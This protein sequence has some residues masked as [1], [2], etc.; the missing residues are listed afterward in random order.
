MKKLRNAMFVFLLLTAVICVTL[1]LLF[2]HYS[3]PVGGSSENIKIEI[4][5]NGSQIAEKLKE[6]DLIRSTTFFKIYLKL[7]KVNDLKAGKYDLNK[8]MSLKE[9]VDKLKE[10]NHFSE[11]EISITFKEGITMRDI[12]KVIDANTNNTYDDVMNV[13]KDTEYLKSLVNDYWFITDKILDS[14]IYYPLEGYLFPDTYRFT[15]KEVTVKEIFKKLLDQMDKVLT[16]HKD[17]IENNKYN[18]HEILTL[19]SLCEKEIGSKEE[20]RKNVASVFI[21][22]LNR[23]MSLGS[24]VTTRYSLKI[25]DPK[26]VLK[27]SEYAS[28]NAYNTRS[29]TMAGKLPAGPISTVSEGSILAVLNAPK[30]DYIYFIANIQTGET[31]F[32]TNARE[33]EAKKAELSKING[34]L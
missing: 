26:Q 11:E 3:S 2:R 27:K 28:V 18:V 20:Y 30:T 8:E 21:N 13:F 24:D 25:D 32:Y 17:L 4:S 9:I 6:A 15:S 16:P 10:G 7:F 19:A 23:G 5:G 1:G 29:S 31:F 22:R 34:G 33:F 14:K 12:A